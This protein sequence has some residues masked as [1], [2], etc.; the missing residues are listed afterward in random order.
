MGEDAIGRL[1]HMVQDNELQSKLVIQRID[2][3]QKFIICDE[4]FCAAGGL[5]WLSYRC[6]GPRHE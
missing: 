4:T 1:R 2:T 6:K 5:N 3:R